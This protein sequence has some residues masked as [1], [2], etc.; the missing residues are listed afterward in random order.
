MLEKLKKFEA[1]N[2]HMIAGGNKTA[3]QIH[4]IQQETQTK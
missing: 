2:V 1:Q 4:Q 3:A